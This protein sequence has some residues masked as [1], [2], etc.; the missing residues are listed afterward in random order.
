RLLEPETGREF[1][2]LEDPNLEAYPWVGF[3]PDGT[4][5]ITTTSVK[6]RGVHVWDL[7]A[8]R[9][10]LKEMD[11]DWDAPDYPPSPKETVPLRLGGQG[12]GGFVAASRASEHL[13]KQRHEEAAAELEKALALMPQLDWAARELARLLVLGPAPM[14]DA[15]KAVALAE[16]AV[17][18]S[19]RDATYKSTLGMAYYR[20]GRWQAARDMLE[21]SQRDSLG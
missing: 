3:S 7:P 2:R 17:K 8:L 1:A 4:R 6:A 16:R 15:A 5:L 13:E 20:A 11:L 14:R 12:A 9:A 10:R 21:A 19:P 18:L